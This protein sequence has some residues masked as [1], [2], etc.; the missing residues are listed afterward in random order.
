MAAFTLV[1][2]DG[3]CS[4]AATSSPEMILPNTA[5]AVAPGNGG[6][7]TSISY[8]TQPNA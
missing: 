2:M 4:A 8:S 5:W 6:S 1:G 3:R 7:P